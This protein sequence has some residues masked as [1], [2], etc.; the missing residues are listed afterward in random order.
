MTSSSVALGAALGLVG[1]DVTLP[2]PLAAGLGYVLPAPT[3]SECGWCACIMAG[4]LPV[5]TWVGALPA[6]DDV[7]V[8]SL[9]V[10]DAGP[11]LLELS[12]W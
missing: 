7:G 3:G 6:G 10:A 2:A 8:F 5:R 1:G 9:A 11:K 4:L 12:R